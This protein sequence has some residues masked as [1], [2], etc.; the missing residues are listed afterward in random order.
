MA[1]PATPAG[2]EVL[3][4][5]VA[6]NL[7]TAAEELVGAFEAG[8]PHEVRL[9][10]GSTGRLF[11]QVEAGAPFDVFL[12]ADTARPARL[13]QSGRA[14]ARRTYATGRLVVAGPADAS[15]FSALRGARV[16]IATPEV[17]PYGVAALAAL[18][19]AGLGPGDMELRQG[20]NVAQVAHFLVTGNATWGFLAASLVPDLLARRE[21]TITPVP[22][23]DPSI[24][25]Q[26]GVLLTGTPAARAF[27]DWLAGPEAGAILKA[28]G[29]EVPG[30]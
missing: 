21:V 17:A 28:S 4:V 18:A 10:H 22:L 7:L 23:D 27:W 13:E 5:A 12:A 30:A 8:S 11:A 15:D 24:L 25:R 19:G 14:L 9:V 16:A 29:Y 26:D 2:A 3:T 1:T 6:A 20:E